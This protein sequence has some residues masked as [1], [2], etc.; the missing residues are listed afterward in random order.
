MNTNTVPLKNTATNWTFKNQQAVSLSELFN[1]KK[2]IQEPYGK[3]SMIYSKN[4]GV[5]TGGPGGQTQG[6][7]LF[8]GVQK[9]Y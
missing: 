1:E 7:L 2:K 3:G 9:F 4:R 6:I 8:M 5:A